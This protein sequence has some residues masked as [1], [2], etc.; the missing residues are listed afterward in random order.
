MELKAEGNE[1]TKRIKTLLLT[2]ESFED[3]TI[4]AGIVNG[5]LNGR[6]FVIY[7]E[8][9]SPINQFTFNEIEE[10]TT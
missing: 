6:E 10:E 1:I 2:T 7:D 8:F 9:G 5:I 4:L 3:E